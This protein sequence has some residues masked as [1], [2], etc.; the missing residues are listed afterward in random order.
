MIANGSVPLAV[1][2]PCHVI[3]PGISP[4][5]GACRCCQMYIPPPLP[6]SLATAFLFL[7]MAMGVT[8]LPLTETTQPR[9]KGLS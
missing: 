3:S 7:E 6:P 9:E 4:L 5:K 2:F 8:G 1:S